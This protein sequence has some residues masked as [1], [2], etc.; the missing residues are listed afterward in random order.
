M[1]RC[2]MMQSVTNYEIILLNNSN[3]RI[4]K[5]FGV[6]TLSA[7]PFIILMFSL[8]HDNVHLIEK[9]MF[10]DICIIIIIV[11]GFTYEEGDIFTFD[12]F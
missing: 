5:W 11:L 2:D 6:H 3:C 8:I 4:S 12:C 1:A 9:K 10:R 7:L